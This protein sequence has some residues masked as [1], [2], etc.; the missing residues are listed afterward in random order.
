MINPE[1]IKDIF[2]HYSSPIQDHS[3][4][5]ENP[6]IPLETFELSR[7]NPKITQDLIQNVSSPVQVIPKNP[8]IPL[9]SQDPRHP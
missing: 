1:L 4:D 3:E 2:H 7:I 5:P 8:E 9:I 6:L